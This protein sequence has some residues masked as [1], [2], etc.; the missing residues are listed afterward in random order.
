MFRYTLSLQFLE[1]LTDLVVAEV[2]PHK[3]IVANNFFH[4]HSLQDCH[5]VLEARARLLIG[6]RVEKPISDFLHGR[7]KW[8]L[9]TA[10]RF[11]FGQPD[12]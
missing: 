3:S 11:A 5:I 7:R 8:P 4:L 6:F 2:P 9:A 10:H 12:S 1:Y